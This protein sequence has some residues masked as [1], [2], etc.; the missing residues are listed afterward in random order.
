VVFFNNTGYLGMCGHGLMGVVRT[1]KHLGRLEEGP[2]RLDTP[3]GEVAAQLLPD[4][5]IEIENVPS[6]CHRMGVTLDLPPYGMIQ[7]DV[8][9]GGN[10]FFIC[11]VPGV[12][13]ELQRTRELLTISSRIAETLR[14]QNITGHGG[15]EIDHVELSGPPLRIDADS[16]NFVFC[17]GGEYDRSPC[18]TGT[19]AKL[20]SLHARGALLV[21][22][23]YRQESITGSLFAARLVEQGG[24]LVPKLR[25]RAY[26]TAESTI[27]FQEGDPFRAGL[28]GEAQRA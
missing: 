27:F 1:L 19:S 2:V 16:R 10:W 15:A 13:L 22:E 23:E 12:S 21:G 28:A 17:P 4:D 5:S 24:D 18:G 7:G 9:Y 20:A 14:K 26:V 25:G 6:F 11:E 3:A 8:A